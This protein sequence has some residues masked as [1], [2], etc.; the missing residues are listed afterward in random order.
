[1]VYCHY[2]F[3]IAATHLKSGGC[4][5]TK[6]VLLCHTVSYAITQRSSSDVTAR[7][8]VAYGANGANKP[9]LPA[10]TH[11]DKGSQWDAKCLQRSNLHAPWPL[12]RLRIMDVK[13]QV[14]LSYLVE[15]GSIFWQ[16]HIISK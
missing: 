8:L 4:E 12:P 3:V 15:T 13:D 16:S 1:M 6:C 7:P 5:V 14:V 10:S 11:P 2:I 9:K